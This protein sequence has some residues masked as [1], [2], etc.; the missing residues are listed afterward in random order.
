M[1]ISKGR[2][3]KHWWRSGGEFKVGIEHIFYGKERPDH[4]AKLLGRKRGRNKN[5][6]VVLRK[7]SFCSKEI[8][9]LNYRIKSKNIYCNQECQN[10]FRVG[11]N[12]I[13]YIHGQG[14]EPYTSEFNNEFKKHIKKKYNYICQNCQ[15]TEREH[16]I[17]FNEILSVHHIDYN[18]FNNNENNLICLCRNCNTRANFNRD[19]WEGFY[20]NKINFREVKYCEQ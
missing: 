16:I 13:N 2:G 4:S 19:Y 20:K 15:I 6:V 11:K 8:E 17:V 1:V 3:K 10:K 5:T 12:A 7:C 14:Y 18:K 9:A